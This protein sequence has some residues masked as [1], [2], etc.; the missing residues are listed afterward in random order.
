M[1]LM[2]YSTKKN[3]LWSLRRKRYTFVE[4]VESMKEI[5][6]LSLPE[7]FVLILNYSKFKHSSAYREKYP[8]WQNFLIPLGISLMYYLEVTI[9]S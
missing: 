4:A 6:Y 2:Q 8:Y 7:I 5:L 3:K 1:I 9:Y